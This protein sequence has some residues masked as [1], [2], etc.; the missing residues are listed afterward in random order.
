MKQRIII[1]ILL[2]I[3]GIAICAIGIWFH[4][5]HLYERY[6]GFAEHDYF[7]S[8]WEYYW[9]LGKS[10][11]FVS[12]FLGAILS[13]SGIYMLCKKPWWYKA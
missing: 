4:M 12:V 3:L 1:A 13:G 2:I 11:L 9:A 6:L 8:F 7:A 10:N 5:N